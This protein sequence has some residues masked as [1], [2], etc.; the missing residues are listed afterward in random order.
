MIAQYM[1]ADGAKIHGS[2]IQDA[3]ATVIKLIAMAEP[4]IGLPVPET[5]RNRKFA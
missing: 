4:A 3:R 2:V 1:A 5:L